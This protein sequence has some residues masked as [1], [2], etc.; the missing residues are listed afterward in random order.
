MIND[1]ADMTESIQSRRYRTTELLKVD[2]L[3]AMSKNTNREDSANGS[4][5][6]MSLSRPMPSPSPLTPLD[7]K[8]HLLSS[9][10][11]NLSQKHNVIRQSHRV[12]M[13]SCYIL[14]LH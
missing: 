5:T 8:H 12:L 2:P 13:W 1:E 10:P 4:P 14:P 6:F 3:E 9:H 7:Y 11:Q